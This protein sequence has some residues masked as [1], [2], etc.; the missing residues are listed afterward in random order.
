MKK[1]LL[2]ALIC[3]FIF[4]LAVKAAPF[5]LDNVGKGLNNVA[6]GGIETPDSV[7]KTNSKGTPAFEDCTDKTKDDVGRG[8][9]RVV[10]G[11]FQIA[12]FW[13]TPEDKSATKSVPRQK[14]VDTTETK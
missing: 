10:G 8:I 2:L 6:Y 7:N 14:T 12:T 5:K 13:Y 3:M 1:I 11:L 4:S 9:A